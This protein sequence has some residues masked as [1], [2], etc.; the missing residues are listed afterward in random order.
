MEA[1][2]SLGQGGQRINQPYQPDLGGVERHEDSTRDTGWVS[3]ISLPSNDNDMLC[4]RS[5]PEN[6]RST[7]EDTRITVERS[8]GY[9]VSLHL[10]G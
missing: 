9:S 3:T 4:S 6:I 5:L 7:C 10:E 8:S 1:T 2:T